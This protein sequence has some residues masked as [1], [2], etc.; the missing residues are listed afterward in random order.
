MCRLSDA[1]IAATNRTASQHH[2]AILDEVAAS[3]AAALRWLFWLH[4][5]LCGEEASNVGQRRNRHTMPAEFSKTVFQRVWRNDERGFSGRSLLRR[6]CSNPVRSYHVT[7]T[8]SHSKRAACVLPPFLSLLHSS[9]INI[10]WLWQGFGLSHDSSFNDEIRR[11][12][13][14]T[15]F[16]FLVWVNPAKA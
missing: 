15:F 11:L 2:A 13:D 8:T 4:G 7:L 16:F 3:R 9:W 10:D 1:Q 14:V 5:R 6:G 12:D